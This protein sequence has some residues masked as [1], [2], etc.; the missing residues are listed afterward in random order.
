MPFK[1]TSFRPQTARMHETKLFAHFAFS[2]GPN[3]GRKWQIYPPRAQVKWIEGSRQVG[4]IKTANDSI[5]LVA[6]H[7][8]SWLCR[9]VIWFW[10]REE[11]EKTQRTRNRLNIS[12]SCFELSC[13]TW[14]YMKVPW[15][16]VYTCACTC[17][18]VAPYL[19]R[20]GNW[21]N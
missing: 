14:S 12:K 16:Q 3:L 13:T 15:Y 9:G 2:Q 17:Y 19:G 8:L 18:I 20:S 5:G 1:R 10:L 4:G 6:R 11:P 21:K 7:A